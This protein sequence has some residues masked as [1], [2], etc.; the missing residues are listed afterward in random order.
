MM[1]AMDGVVYRARELLQKYPDDTDVNVLTPWG[2]PVLAY[3]SEKGYEEMVRL[4]LS[5]PDIDV[6]ARKN[7]TA[8]MLAF[9]EKH[10]QCAKL[11]LEDP[12]TDLL[13]TDNENCTPLN[14]L[15]MGGSL[16][17]LEV[18]IAS[19]R[20]MRMD[21]MFDYYSYH[22]RYLQLKEDQPLI[23]QLL[24]D[25]NR[26]PEGVR[27]RVRKDTGWYNERAAG[28]LAPVVFLSDGLV[29]INN[30]RRPNGGRKFLKIISQLPLELQMV[31][32]YRAAGSGRSLVP[33]EKRESAFREL[34]RRGFAPHPFV[35]NN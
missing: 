17:L 3:A 12:R 30:V 5:H 9:H 7:N 27:H 20:E 14:R 32:C 11:L 24:E 19:G 10:T 34:A 4:L 33:N 21:E 16:E 8:F 1:A 6:N 15:L 18:W 23:V 28:F 29:R 2:V 26:D 35:N 13:I 25:F 31:L 22:P